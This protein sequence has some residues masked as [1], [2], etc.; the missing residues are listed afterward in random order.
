MRTERESKEKGIPGS[1]NIPLN[2]LTRRFEEIPRDRPV[3]IHCATGYRSSIGASFLAQ[4]GYS[5]LM[6]LV[7]G[8]A[9]W[10]TSLGGQ[11]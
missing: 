5:R 1:V 2:Q 9:A 8:Y 11:A 3:A 4:R 7:G 6:D 10:E